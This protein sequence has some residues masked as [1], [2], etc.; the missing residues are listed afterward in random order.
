[1][2]NSQSISYPRL[3]SPVAQNA[4]KPSITYEPDLGFASLWQNFSWHFAVFLFFA[5]TAHV[6]HSHCI[7]LIYVNSPKDVKMPSRGSEK[8]A[9]GYSE[10]LV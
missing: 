5:R 3:F 8:N 6:S 1:M 9:N 2:L 4:L 7:V 10:L